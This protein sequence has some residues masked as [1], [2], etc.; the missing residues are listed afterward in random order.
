MEGAEKYDRVVDK[1][2]SSSVAQLL[3]WIR[4]GSKVLEFGPATGAMTRLLFEHSRCD[5]TCVEVDAKA[6]ESAQAFCS[7]MIVGDLNDTQWAQGLS[8]ERFDYIIFADVLEHLL[9]PAHALSFS[10]TFL[11]P[12]GEVLISVPNIAYIGVISELLQG[13]FNYRRDGLLD[14]THVHFFTRESLVRLLRDA[15]LVSVEWSR[16]TVAPEFSEFRLQA[17]QLGAAVRGVLAAVPD[18]DTYQFLVRAS[19][20]GVAAAP[21]VPAMRELARTV[22][23][24]QIFFDRG[25]GFGELD[26][27]VLPLRA[28]PDVQTLRVECPK[29]T[30]SIRLDPIDTSEAVTIRSM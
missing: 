18:G 5:I 2:G 19:L 17:N 10:L 11:K 7:R 24:A 8:D 14:E 4:P 9:D 16:T 15:G 13:R 3:R 27:V 23:S 30:K 6:A 22:R 1:D 12:G 21:E 28:T 29:G 20:T 25:E 26:S